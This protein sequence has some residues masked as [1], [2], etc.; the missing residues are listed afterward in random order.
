MGSV[1]AVSGCTTS[2]I[3]GDCEISFTITSNNTS[4]DPATKFVWGIDVEPSTTSPKSAQVVTLTSGQTSATV[5]AYVPGP[6]PHAI[7]AYAE[8]AAGNV[9]ADSGTNDPATFTAQEDPATTPYSSWSAALAAKASWDNVMIA[10]STAS[11]GS[12]N[13]DG[14]GTSFDLADLEAEGWNPGGQV[15]VDGAT[16]TLPDF[17]TGSPDNLLA[18]NQ[19]IDLPAGSQGTSLVFLATAANASEPARTQPGCQARH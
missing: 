7:Y 1:A 13:G 12:G 19:T 17:G 9:S 11:S 16:F 6:G 5:D 3:T 8:D 2:A 14:G 4:A 10:T 15:T 18:A